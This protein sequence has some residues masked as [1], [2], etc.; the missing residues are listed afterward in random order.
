MTGKTMTVKEM[1]DTILKNETNIVLSEK[2]K[3]RIT[4][5]KDL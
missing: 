5:L 1:L 4:T 2:D 3:N